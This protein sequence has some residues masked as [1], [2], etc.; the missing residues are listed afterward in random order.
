MIQ[1]ITAAGDMTK[2][3]DSA[4]VPL[5]ESTD[6]MDATATQFR[7]LVRCNDNPQD[8][9]NKRQSNNLSNLNQISQNSVVEEYK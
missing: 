1:N 2:I 8:L 7:N 6:N 3:T 5:L 4:A 9:T